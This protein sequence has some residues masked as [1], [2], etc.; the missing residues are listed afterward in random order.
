MT[1]LDSISV[2]TV[3]N[4]I[5]SSVPVGRLHCGFPEQLPHFNEATQLTAAMTE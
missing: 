1:N 2:R 4:I 5:L 3:T